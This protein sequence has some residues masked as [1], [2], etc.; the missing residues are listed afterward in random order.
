MDIQTNKPMETTAPY[1]IMPDIRKLNQIDLLGETRSM[2]KRRAYDAMKREERKF[3]AIMSQ[4]PG[5][6][7]E[8]S[9][10]LWFSAFETSP[11]NPFIQT[12]INTIKV[13]SNAEVVEDQSS[14][15]DAGSFSDKFKKIPPP[16]IIEIPSGYLDAHSKEEKASLNMMVALIKLQL[17]YSMCL[18]KLNPVSP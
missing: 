16:P 6:H 8:F 7:T 10:K 12:F 15:S 13:L 14:G 4:Y 18:S 3:K 17:I 9:K 2:K 1:T 5:L 11:T